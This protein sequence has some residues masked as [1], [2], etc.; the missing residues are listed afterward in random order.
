MVYSDLDII[1]P[2][3]KALSPEIDLSQAVSKNLL[4]QL[5]SSLKSTNSNVR[6]ASQHAS[7]ILFARCDES[8]ALQAIAEALLKALKE[9]LK[10][11][12]H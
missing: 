1:P 9:G 3:C 8:I 6:E 7:T 4:P 5:L 10:S 11:L 12:K 2:L